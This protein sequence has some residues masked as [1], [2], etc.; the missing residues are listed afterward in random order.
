MKEEN[1]YNEQGSNNLPDYLRVNPFNVPE[2]YFDMLENNIL[3]RVTEQ[4][5]KTL[6]S[7]TGF[8]VPEGYFEENESA[9]LGRI[10]EQKLK[11]K[12]ST[13]GYQIPTGYFDTLST[14]IIDSV[15][16]K[17]PIVRKLSTR[18][19]IRYAGAA[20]VAIF[21]GLGS[22]WY[23]D[24]TDPKPVNGHDTQASLHNISKDELVHYLVQETEGVELI[25]LATYLDNEE[26]TET[27][28]E[29]DKHL[30]D[31]EIEEYLNYML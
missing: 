3:D 15:S 24:S 20:A 8:E 10:A 6:A 11:D 25:E 28:F 31:K 26:I 4:R 23:L 19:W 2:G 16:E 9:I 12:V 17:Q 27:P 21:L 13:D 5:L 30:K 7:D 29:I 22:Y 14:R 1:T 18:N